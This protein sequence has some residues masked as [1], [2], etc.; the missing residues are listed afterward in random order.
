[1][2]QSLGGANFGQGEF[3]AGVNAE[4]VTGQLSADEPDCA[5]MTGVQVQQIAKQVS[6]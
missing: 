4:L 2:Y 3:L 1:M 6:S 5:G